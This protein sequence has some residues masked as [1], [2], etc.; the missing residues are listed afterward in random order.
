[1]SSEV[2]R[3]H[4]S[5]RRRLLTLLLASVVAAWTATTA[6]AYIHSHHEL[7]AILDAHLAQSARLLIAQSGHE[8]EEIDFEDLGE[9]SPYDQ[10]VAFQVWDH[11]RELV[12]RSPDAPDKPFSAV[13]QGFS[14]VDIGGRRWRVF[15]GW[16]RGNAVLVQVAEDDAARATLLK[17]YALN[18]LRSLLLG[19]PVLAL[20]IGWVV[21]RALR[22][23]QELGEQVGR[24]GPT[25]LEPLAS[26]GAPDE[27][28]PLVERLNALFVRIADSLAAERRFTSHAAHELRTPL[29]AIRAQAEVAADSLDAGQR[30][31][32]LAHV[33]EGCDRAGRLVDQM[34]LLARIDE[35][36]ARPVP[37][38]CRLGEV[39]ARVLADL[40]PAALQASVTLELDDDSAVSG[41]I[42]AALLEVALRNLVDNA[43]RHG[44]SPGK[45]S[46]RCFE[47][48]GRACVEVS[49]TGPGVAPEELSQLGARFHRVPGTHARGS[50][51][52]LSI[53]ER[54]AELHGGAVSYSAGSGQQG[55]CVRLVLPLHRA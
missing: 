33:I 43:V 7:D 55:F 23:L 3:A 5:L 40:A 8:L 51:L 41:Q 29:A 30:S 21:R 17:R 28:K 35:L 47:D 45:V 9:P 15:S 44:G 16:A 27:V 54:I 48:A 19:L 2:P 32:A 6:L 26:P 14:D 37:A 20:L 4:Y 12:L 10:V 50:G 31:A 39:A 22:P 11:G 24:L 49:D 46:V 25:D 36:Q 52:G 53:V 13:E 38:T 42:D 34:L 18:S 1:M